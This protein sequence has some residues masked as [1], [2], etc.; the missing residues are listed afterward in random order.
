MKQRY[1]KL[2]K[3]A[4]QQSQETPT[5]GRLYAGLAT[6][7]PVALSLARD[8]VEEGQSTQDAL[9]DSMDVYRSTY[10]PS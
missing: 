9:E 5:A 10:K 1:A 8:S 4:K 6:R 7:D 3:L 2:R